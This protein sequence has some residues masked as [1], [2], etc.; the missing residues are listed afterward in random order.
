MPDFGDV[1]ERKGWDVSKWSSSEEIDY[2]IIWGDLDQEHRPAFSV[3]VLERNTAE[4]G[5]E[6][7]VS[8]RDDNGH[9]SYLYGTTDLLAFPGEKSYLVI[10]RDKLRKWLE[11]NVTKDY[12]TLAHQALMKVYTKGKSMSTLVKTYHLKGLSTGEMMYE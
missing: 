8:L 1:A 10:E 2:V 12:V 4:Q 9:G 7:W 6:T 5:E 11:D 3:K